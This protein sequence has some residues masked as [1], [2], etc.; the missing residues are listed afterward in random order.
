[1]HPKV[2][3]RCSSAESDRESRDPLTAARVWSA[4]A[5]TDGIF[6][7]DVANRLTNRVQLTTD[8]YG[9]YL[10]AVEEAFENDID[11]AMLVKK[12]GEAPEAEKRYSPAV[13]VGA[14]RQVVHGDPDPEHISTS[15]VE[16]QIFRCAWGSAASR[17]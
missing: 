13:C 12:Y 3:W 14:D 1:V 2:G 5:K 15:Y 11:Y 6:M 7:R 9:V 10:R 8:G 16:R 17:A 4:N